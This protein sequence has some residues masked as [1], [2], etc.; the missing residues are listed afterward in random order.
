MLRTYFHKLAD[1][2]DDGPMEL[3]DTAGTRSR[4][5]NHE[6]GG[7]PDMGALGANEGNGQDFPALRFFESRENIGRFAACGDADGYVALA[8]KCLNLPDEHL[9]VGEIVGDARQNARV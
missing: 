4:G 9:V 7:R 8:P 1:A 6:I 3:Q 2:V 5:C